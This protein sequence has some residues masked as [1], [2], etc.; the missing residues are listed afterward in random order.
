LKKKYKVAGIAWFAVVFFLLSISYFVYIVTN[1]EKVKQEALELGRAVQPFSQKVRKVSEHVCPS[2]VGLTMEGSSKYTDDQLV[3]LL[4][5]FGRDGSEGCMPRGT[6]SG[7]LIDRKGHIVTNH[8]VIEPF[9]DGV[10]TVIAFDKKQYRPA[11]I[12][13]IDPLTD[14]AV[15]KIEGGDFNS[16]EFG[17]DDDVFVGDW[18]I[19]IGSPYGLH[20]S[21]SSGVVSAKNRTQLFPPDDQ[22]QCEEYLQVDAAI[23]RGNSGGPLV[24]LRGELIGINCGLST[25]SGGFEGIAFAIPVDVVRYVT[26]EIILHGKVVRGYLGIRTCDIDD[27]LAMSIGFSDKQALVRQRGFLAEN[28]AFVTE[29]WGV[30]PASKAGI[31]PGDIITELNGERLRS[32]SDLRCIADRA[33]IGRTLDMKIMRDNIEHSIKITVE[34]RPES[35][36]GFTLCSYN[37]E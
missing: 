5:S 22:F 36:A 24:N 16:I 15:V 14:L 9:R 2:A 25:L 3:A 21:V 23:N 12:I 26:K 30:T 35:F 37:R 31:V 34:E 4:E 29:V 6:G 10:I 28:G 33:S 19:A 17:R 8:H 1:N 11:K 32:R 27:G 13:G 7:V 18:V 20:H